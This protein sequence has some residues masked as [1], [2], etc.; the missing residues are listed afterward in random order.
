MVQRFFFDRIDAKPGRAPIGR[1]YHPVT[2]T[3][4]HKAQPPLALVQFAETWANVTLDAAVDKPVPVPRRKMRTFEFLF[5]TQSS[6][7]GGEGHTIEPARF[8]TF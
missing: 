8:A 7:T 4:P 5:H 6:C 2:G 3:R 1:E